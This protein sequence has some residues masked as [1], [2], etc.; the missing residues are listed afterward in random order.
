MANG[1][2]EWS[3]DIK[4]PGKTAEQIYDRMMTFLT[5]MTKE[6]NQ[7][8]LSQVALVNKQNHIIVAKYTEWL[9]FSSSFLALDQTKFNYTLIVKCSDNEVNVKLC[10]ISYIY[11]ENCSSGGTYKAEEWIDDGNALNKKKT[12]LSKITGKFRKKTIDRKDYIFKT[13][14]KVLNSNV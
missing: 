5:D 4:V 2:I 8:N 11:E 10:R 3:T 13:I 14:D 1:K 12:K 7:T 9:V 6:E